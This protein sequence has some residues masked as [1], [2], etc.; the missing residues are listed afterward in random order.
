MISIITALFIGIAITFGL[1]TAP[2]VQVDPEVADVILYEVQNTGAHSP[3]LLIHIGTRASCSAVVVDGAY[4]L[5]AAHCVE[6][7]SG[8][9]TSD[10]IY[11]YDE[12]HIDTKIV[13]KAAALDHSR[14]IALIRGNFTN[15]ARS[16]VDFNGDKQ[17][18]LKGLPV[19]SCGFP[20][21]GERYCVTS[22]VVSNTNFKLF[23]QGGILYQGMSG[24]PVVDYDMNVIGVNSAVGGDFIIFG[25][26]V[27]VRALWGL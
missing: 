16:K 10:D 15:F 26:V 7:S 20:A 12:F 24:G 11:I 18:L 27:G 1:R 9:L 6:D 5:T 17:F 13:A 14:D 22:V 4:A 21:G 25:S 19:I 23:A 8:Y 3:L 2:D